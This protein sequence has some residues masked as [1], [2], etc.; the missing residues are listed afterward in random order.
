MWAEPPLP[1]SVLVLDQSAPHRPWSTA[2]IGAVQSNKSDKAGRPISYHI[3]HLDLFG[4]GKRQYDDNLLNHLADIY[5]SQSFGV[6]L[7]IEPNALD[8]AVKLRA[9]VWPTVPVVFTALSVRKRAAPASAENNRYFRSED[10][11][12]HGEDG[13]NDTTESQAIGPRRQPFR[14]RSL[15]SAIRQRNL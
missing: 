8:F 2:I 14:R 1:P 7:S 11:C 6:I 10:V 3:E 9:R 13:K 12:Q 15:L 4:F 5:D